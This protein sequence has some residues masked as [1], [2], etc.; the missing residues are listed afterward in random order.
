[1]DEKLRKAMEPLVD[2]LLEKWSGEV[3]TKALAKLEASI[4][5]TKEMMKGKKGR[6]GPVGDPDACVRMRKIVM[7]EEVEGA[8]PIERDYVK[9]KWDMAV[10]DIIKEEG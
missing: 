3:T 9:S 10:K 1:M 2:M 4:A 5:R 6:T 7:G 8:A